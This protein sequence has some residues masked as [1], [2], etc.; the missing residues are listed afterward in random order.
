MYAAIATC[1]DITFTVSILS[2][3]LE[4]PGDIHWDAV[5]CVFHYLQGTKDFQLTYGG[6]QHDLEGYSD[7][8]GGTQEDWYT[9]S[10][11]TFLIDGGAIA[12]SSRKQ[13]LI[14]LSMEEAEYVA[15]MHYGF[16]SLYARSFPRS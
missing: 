13:E 14:T 3:F 1:P 10:R 5:K 11:Y 4:N 6:E 2:R 8:N 12:W 9:I 7:T 15:M 16:T